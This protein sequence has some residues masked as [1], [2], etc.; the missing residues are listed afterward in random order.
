[1][2]SLLFKRFL[3]R[4]LQVAYIIPSSKALI[5]RVM[6]KL[7]FSQPRIIVEFGPGEGCHTR[8]LARQMHPDSRLLLFELDPE[9]AD[10]LK[11][12]FAGDP[13]VEVLNTDAANLKEELSTRGIEFCDYVVSGIPFS[14]LELTKKRSI[15]RAVYDSLAPNAASAFVIYQ[16][17]NELK[18]HATMFPRTQSEYFIQNIPP[19]VVTVYYK[20]AAQNGNGTNGNGTNGTHRD[21]KDIA[22]SAGR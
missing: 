14:I 2:S 11:E 10:H 3:A 20:Q 1:M 12:Q 21:S 19:M 22:G 15:L 6:S 7:D 8:E 5:R 9:L 18:Q 4:P 17:T 16:C 13:R